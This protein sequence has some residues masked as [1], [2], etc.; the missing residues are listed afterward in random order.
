MGSCRRVAVLLLAALASGLLTAPSALAAPVFVFTG[1]GWGHGIGMSQY[2]AQGFAQHGFT[3]DEILAHYYEGSAFSDPQPNDFVGVLLATGRSALA[4]G[5][6]AAFEISGQPFAP[7]QYTVTPRPGA[8]VVSRSGTTRTFSSPATFFP[9]AEDLEL[10]GLPYRGRLVVASSEAG[11][12][13]AVLNRVRRES[14]LRGVVPREMPSSWLAEALQAQAVAARSYAFATGGH[15]LW[16]GGEPVFCPDT[17]D[18]V[19]G[20]KSAETAATN[21]AVQATAGEVVT[22]AGQIATTYFFSTSGGK[23]AAKSDEWGGGPVP[24]LVS[25]VDPH[26]SISPHHAWGPEDAEVDCP[27]TSADCVFTAAQIRTALGLAQS[28]LDLQVTARNSSSRVSSLEARG[29]TATTTFSGSAARAD[30][31]LRSTWFN[32]GVLS[33]TSS[34]PTVTYGGS[35]TLSGLA[36]SGGTS[37]WGA[38]DLQRKRSGEAGWTRIATALPD[39][40]WSRVV[41]PIVATDYRV[42][43]GNAAGAASRVSVRTRVTISTP[44]APHTKLSGSIGPA[45][46]GIAVT[47]Q[48]MRRDGTWAFSARTQTGESGAFSFALSRLGTYRVRADAGAGYLRGSARVTLP[49]V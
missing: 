2:G 27:G 8:V 11:S 42:V 12:S 39:G 23:T 43:S 9:G 18:Q 32:V 34:V 5:S 22:H 29:A 44:Q 40:S 3:Y 46:S 38:A 33:V 19:Y 28:P 17:R 1:K 16:L 7:G 26:D 25:V 31:G 49:P 4:V 20:G 6:D 10:G 47:L 48:R 15:C 35:V 21:A 13:L 41:K 30:L 14:Y 37:G 36:R 45:R 24:Y